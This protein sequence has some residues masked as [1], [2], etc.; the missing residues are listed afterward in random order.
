MLNA[1]LRVHQTTSVDADMLLALA[2][3]AVAGRPAP[4]ADGVRD[5]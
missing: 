4:A 3:L 5:D 1:D 2:P